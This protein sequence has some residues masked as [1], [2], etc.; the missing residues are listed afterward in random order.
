MGV[1]RGRAEATEGEEES[2]W[3]DERDGGAE[4]GRGRE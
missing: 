2:T 1:A 3:E 4:P